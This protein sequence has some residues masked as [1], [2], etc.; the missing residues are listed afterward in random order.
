MDATTQRSIF[1]V[2]KMDCPSEERM[3][4]IALEGAK[5]DHLEFDLA[6]RRLSVWHTDA[7]EGIAAR[8]EPL[9]YG[10]KLRNS[11]RAEAPAKSSSNHADERRTLQWALAINAGMFLVEIIAGIVGQSMGLIADSLDMFADATVYAISLYVV[12]GATVTKLRAAHF[13]GWLQMA[14][15]AGT[16]FEVGR[17]FVVGS[18]PASA[19]MIVIATVAL[20]ANVI[21]LRMLTPYSAGGAHMKASQICTT[22]DV[23]ANFGVIVAALL[24][25]WSG[26]RMPDLILGAI[27]AIVVFVG[28]LKILRLR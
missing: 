3:V 18:E 5:I 15:A 19:I 17:R 1:D 11:E 2:P 9:G 4:R 21:V 12:G 22:V 6:A 23:M 10:A 7:V 8:L 20:V 14:L 25:M 26:S 13:S 16:L 27:I 28:A 24:V